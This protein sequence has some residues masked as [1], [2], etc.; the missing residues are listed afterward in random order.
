MTMNPPAGANLNICLT[1]YA[2]HS[3]QIFKIRQ[4]V[5]HQ[6][7]GIAADLDMDGQ[8]A[9]ADQFIAFIKAQP[10]GVARLRAYGDQLNQAKIERV[11][12]LSQFRS[13]GIGRAMIQRMLAHAHQRNFARALVYAQATSIPFYEKLGFCRQGDPFSQAGIPHLAL[14]KDL[15]SSSL[16]PE[17]A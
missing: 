12:V 17:Y 3:S 15:C 5:F 14:V 16:G 8:D 9:D 6:E 10:V 7:Q 13:Q 11:A 4:Q 2:T 1:S